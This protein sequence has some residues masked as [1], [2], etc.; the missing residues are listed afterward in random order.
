LS[1]LAV[2]DS[3]EIPSLH[4]Y[5]IEPTISDTVDGSNE[6]QPSGEESKHEPPSLPVK[7]SY[8]AI[9][10]RKLELVTRSFLHPFQPVVFGSPLLVRIRDLEGFTGKD[11]YS[12]ISKRM[13]RFVPR[14]TQTDEGTT[15]QH[16]IDTGSPSAVTRQARRGRQHR[17]KTTSDMESLCA[18]DT[19]AHGFRLRIVSRDGT[20]C[21]LC[22]WFSSC[23][24]CVIPCD[25]FP[26][27][28]MCGDSIA[29]DWHLSVDLSGGGFGWKVG[30]NESSGINVQA[31]LHTRA[32]SRIK[33]HSSFDLGGKRYGYSGSITLE[34][35]LDSFAKEERIPEVRGMSSAVILLSCNRANR[36][37]LTFQ[38]VAIGI[39]LKLQRFSSPNKKDQYLALPSC[40]NSSV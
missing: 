3:G 16:T 1:K 5:E 14:P 32:Q 15:S 21:S 33:K 25:D 7:Y 31:S 17:H 34:E 40:C 2:Q 35:C 36:I 30:T 12:F 37:S 29:V 20:R 26:A 24:G 27:I 11:L 38:L 9:S 23:V 4:V 19:P 39:L 8:L 6:K 13:Q 22:P 10:Q 28:A 18:G